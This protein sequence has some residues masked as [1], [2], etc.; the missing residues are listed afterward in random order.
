M[1]T[2]AAKCSTP[3]VFFRDINMQ[4]AKDIKSIDNLIQDNVNSFLQGLFQSRCAHAQLRGW[5]STTYLVMHKAANRNIDSDDDNNNYNANKWTKSNIDLF[6]DFKK[7]N[8]PQ[9]KAWAEDVWTDLDAELATADGQSTIYTHKA[10]AEFIFGSIIP[11]LQKMIQNFIT[12]SQLW[13]NGPYVWAALVYH[14]FLSPIALKM[15]ILHKIKSPLTLSEHNHD[16][17]SYCAALINMNAVVDMMA[18]TDELVTAFLML[19]N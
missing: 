15:T 7:F 18:N 2:D 11:S 3:K 6:K 14:F 17:K 9:M 12:D 10:L 16:L 5:T 8:L 1:A 19:I 13:N 4:H